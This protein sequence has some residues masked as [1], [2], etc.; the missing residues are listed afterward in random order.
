MHKK[1][2][3]NIESDIDT[4][5]FVTLREWKQSKVIIS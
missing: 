5:M 4:Q 1:Y 3:I 2:D